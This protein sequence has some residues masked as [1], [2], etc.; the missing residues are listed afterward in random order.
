MYINDSGLK[1]D[2]QK[3]LINKTRNKIVLDIQA[4]GFKF[5]QLHID[6][7]LGNKPISLS[8][9]KKIESYVLENL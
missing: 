1:K 7:F 6:R 4:K 5:H 9:L 3:I 8:T 2:L